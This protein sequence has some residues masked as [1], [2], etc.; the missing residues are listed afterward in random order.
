MSN[1]PKTSGRATDIECPTCGAWIGWACEG[2]NYGYHAAGYHRA[3]Q[4]VAEQAA[5]Q[6]STLP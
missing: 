2:R 5:A 1:Q 4:R 6:R 3:R